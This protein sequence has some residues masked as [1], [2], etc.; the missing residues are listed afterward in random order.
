MSAPT[1]SEARPLGIV[2]NPSS[3]RDARRLFARADSSTLQSKRNQVE[4]IIV[5]AAAAG[6]KEIIL[7]PDA[8]RIAQS[9]CEAIGV[10]VDL[11]LLDF[12]PRNKPSDTAA[13]VEHMREAGCGAL[14]VLG[15]DGTSRIVARTWLDAPILPISTGTNN[16]FPLMLEATVAG[17]AAGA[18][19]AGVVPLEKSAR[20]VKRVAVEIEDEPPDLALIDAVHLVDDHSGNLLPFDPACLRTLVLSRALPDAVGMSPV[21]GL[22]ETCRAEDDFG[23]HVL[24]SAPEAGHRQLLVPVSP[25]L[26]RPVHVAAFRRLNLSEPVSFTGPGLVALDGDRERNLADGQRVVMRVERDGPWLIDPARTLRE[27]ARRGLYEGR[28]DWHDHRDDGGLECC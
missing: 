11:R 25:G 20:I 5:G 2:I 8:F 14:A 23:V 24:C 6:V 21:G 12:R 16:V 13:A 28:S 9:A 4:R 19:A 17:A 1:N 7:A 15:G 26:Y 18:V 3:G 10:R 27:A 22:L